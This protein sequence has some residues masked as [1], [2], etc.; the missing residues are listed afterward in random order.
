MSDYDAWDFDRLGARRIKV[1]A[2][3]DAI[4][5]ALGKK[6]PHERAAG[7]TVAQVMRETGY[8]KSWVET[9]VARAGEENPA[10]TTGAETDRT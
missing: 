9:L 3:L 4:E 2:D 5:R 1:R 6:V 8:A 10:R 7:K